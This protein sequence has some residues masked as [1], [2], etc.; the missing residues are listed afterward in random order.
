MCTQKKE[1]WRSI[2][3]KPHFYESCHCDG[4]SPVKTPMFQLF[5]IK[6]R[7]TPLHSHSTGLRKCV[8]LKILC[9]VK[10]W[11]WRC[12]TNWDTYLSEVA[13]AESYKFRN[14]LL[15]L[16]S[17][18]GKVLIDFL[19]ISIFHPDAGENRSWSF[20]SLKVTEMALFYQS[21]FIC[22][23]VENTET[24][25]LSQRRVLNELVSGASLIRTRY[26]CWNSSSLGLT[27]I[28]IVP[29]EGLLT[30]E[31]RRNESTGERSF[32]IRC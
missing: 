9:F 30:E 17:R 14:L 20:R 3:Y 25:M 19:W 7:S 23:A 10:W 26:S 1:N 12:Q 16:V 6:P 2:A 31:N 18:R 22:P 15:L 13:F 21:Y 8:W 11:G 32:I 29:L 24:V 4:A 27:K 5:P 28:L